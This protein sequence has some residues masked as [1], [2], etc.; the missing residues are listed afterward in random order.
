[1]ETRRPSTV[2]NMVGLHLW[3]VAQL[4]PHQ[5]AQLHPPPQ[6]R[7]PQMPV[8]VP[9]VPS[10]NIS[11]VTHTR[12]WKPLLT[13]LTSTFTFSFSFGQ[14]TKTVLF[15]L[16]HPPP[17]SLYSQTKGK[18]KLRKSCGKCSEGKR[19]AGA[20]PVHSQA[21]GVVTGPLSSPCLITE[22]TPSITQVTLKVRPHTVHL[23]LGVCLSPPNS[24]TALCPHS[25]QIRRSF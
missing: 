8:M 17:S 1:M 5:N 13:H 14:V 20:F 21:S 11:K 24:P 15:L 7:G 2:T 3:G 19:S 4:K 22:G 12:P 9:G 16:P 23:R 18:Q 25:L 6:K 10:C